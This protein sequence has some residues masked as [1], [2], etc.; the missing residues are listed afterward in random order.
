[1]QDVPLIDPE[2]GQKFFG[3]KNASGITNRCDFKRSH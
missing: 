2:F 1:M 3:Q